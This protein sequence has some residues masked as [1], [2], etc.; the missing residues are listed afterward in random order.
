MSK[1]SKSHLHDM[2]VL[3]LSSTILLMGV[4]TRHKMGNAIGMKIGVEALVLPTSIQL[5]RNDPAFK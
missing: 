3:A 2:V 5:N 1:E 4:R